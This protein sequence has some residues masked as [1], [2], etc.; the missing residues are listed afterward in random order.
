VENNHYNFDKLDIEFVEKIKDKFPIIA[1]SLAIHHDK[2]YLRVYILDKNFLKEVLTFC[3][4]ELGYN[5][6]MDL[7]AIDYLMLLEEN[8]NKRFK[9]VYNLF[10]LVKNHR[11]FIEVG[12]SE[13]D[14]EL[15]SVVDLWQSANWFE[16]EVFDMF[17]V[18][19]KNHPNLKRILMYE[20]FEGHPLRKDY[21]INKRQPLVGPLH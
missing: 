8:Y 11:V 13:D 7:F 18:K 15:E 1:S 10:N 14:L 9:V 2:E 5:F 20:G 16:R 4:N 6:L 17:G 12:V 19:F 3:K 21:P